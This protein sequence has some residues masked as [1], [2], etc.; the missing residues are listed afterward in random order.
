MRR[1]GHAKI[2]E[3]DTVDHEI[4]K[5]PG[6]VTDVQ[7]VFVTAVRLGDARFDGN[8][9]FVAVGDHFGPTGEEIAKF[10]NAPR[11]DQLDL[12]IK[13]LGSQLK[14]TLIISLARRAMSVGISTQIPRNLKADFGDQRSSN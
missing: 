13:R 8:V 3:V 14:S 1:N 5:F 10:L 6:L 2:H 7:T 11:C 12:W 4:F 9:F